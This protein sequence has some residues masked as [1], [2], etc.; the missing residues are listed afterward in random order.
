MSEHGLIAPVLGLVG[1][2]FVMWVWMYA[3]RIPAMQEAEVDLEEL[4]R[5]GAP[6]EPCSDRSRYLMN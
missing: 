4:S 1:W 2:T 3:T 6:L 5:T